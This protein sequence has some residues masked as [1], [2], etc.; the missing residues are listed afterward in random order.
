MI[1]AKITNL[2]TNSKLGIAFYGEDVANISTELKKIYKE[3]CEDDGEILCALA[4]DG[5][6]PVSEN[7]FYKK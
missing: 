2:A 6:I 3:G 1:Y 4:N 7:F 5:F